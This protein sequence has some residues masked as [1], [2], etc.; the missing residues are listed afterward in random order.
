MHEKSKLY[1][2]PA[3]KQFFFFSI[4]LFINGFWFFSFVLGFNNYDLILFVD[5]S[6][7][8]EKPEVCKEAQQ[9]GRWFCNW[10]RVN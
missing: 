2:L 6:E 10:G 5:G 1:T 7:I 8:F 9:E 3:T 4:Y